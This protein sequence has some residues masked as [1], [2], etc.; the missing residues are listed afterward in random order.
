[1]SDRRTT[2][3]HQ[4]DLHLIAQSEEQKLLTDTLH[5]WAQSTILPQVQH[6]DEEQ[7]LPAKVLREAEEL[8][9]Y[10]ISVKESLG[11]SEMGYS[12]SLTA[13]E[14]L[15]QYEP[16]LAMKIAL[17]NGPIASLWPAELALADATWANSTLQIN[18]SGASGHLADIPWGES[19]KWLLLPQGDRLYMID[20]QSDR[21]L[22]TA[23]KNRL[24][25]RCAEWVNLQFDGAPTLAYSLRR[26]DRLR[27]QAWMNLGWAAMAIG[28]GKAGIQ[29]GIKYATERVQFKKPIS[30][31]Q[32]IQWMIANSMTE[33]DAARLLMYEAARALESGESWDV[34]EGVRL[35]A[36]ARLL[37]ADAGHQACDRGLQMHGGYGFTREYAVERYWRDVQRVYPAEGREGLERLILNGL[38][39]D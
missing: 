8:G 7:E 19:A 2:V 35:A 33:L 18:G 5:S 36:Q 10:S 27:A 14:V 21:V 37:A 4:S 13:V 39:F 12:S 3:N 20:L 9:L 15:A 11:G 26:R 34:R 22:R 29:E 16:S 1:M 28:A 6:W 31:F 30:E 25:L 23:Q 32:A 24:G 17:L 38:N